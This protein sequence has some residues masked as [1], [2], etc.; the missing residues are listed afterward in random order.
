MKTKKTSTL[1]WLCV[2]LLQYKWLLLLALALTVGSNLFA[3]IGPALCG[4]AIDLAEMGPGKV[5][6]PAVERYALWM[7]LFY[8]AS[9]VMTYLLNVLMIVISRKVTYRM[10]RD[11][12]RRLA[13]LPVGYFDSHP[14]GDIISRISYDTDTINGSLSTDLV[15]IFASVITVAGSLI[16]MLRIAP[17]LVLVFVVTVPLSM[18]ITRR[19]SKKTHPLFRLR[20]R[21]LGE[22][23][24][25]AEEMISGQKTLKA[26]CQEENTLSELDEYNERAVEAYYQAEYHVA[27]MG[28]STNF[29]N[30]LSL[31]LISVFGA[32]MYMAG[33]I[34]VG[35][36]S[37]FVLYSRKFS[38]PIREVADIFNE[39][40][41]SV[42]AAERVFRI[43]DE[44]PEPPDPENARPLGPVQGAVELEH[45]S[46]GYTP[47]R[48]V[49]HDLS[50]QV[51]PGRLIAIVGPTGA[52]KTTL[53][54][55]LMRFYDMDGGK[56]RV[57]GRD[58]AG[59]TRSSL[60]LAYSMVLQDTWLFYGSIYDN[61]AY[62]RP[63]AT[64][65]EVEAAARAAHIDGFI[66]SLP[67]G[68]D[69]ILTD[70]AANISKGQKQLLT[71][72]RAMLMDSPMLILDEATSNVDTRTELLVQQAM[73]ELMRDK[74]CFVVAHRLSTVR[75]ADRILVV[76]DGDIVESGV[77]A[78]LMAKKGFYWELYQAQFA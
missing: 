76:R 11:M 39:L 61:I 19:I 38:G 9:A 77:H 64:R 36:I 27:G 46:F 5:D 4:R 50:L 71:I 30:N 62:G 32:M 55:L 43:M 40:Q 17:K 21:R 13:D 20:S 14:V 3:L 52:G 22:L 34:T 66:R 31:T 68:Y 72:A 16:M 18:L 74:T 45:I 51:Q 37:S 75:H 25:F 53:I 42:A 69:T 8:V 58:C 65:E 29:I 60:R 23:N 12:F 28:P 7:A 56:M 33:G 26:Y 67:Q 73:R 1:R 44:R 57:D 35:N 24:G 78:E 70:D 47:E 41:S 49:L 2:Y 10:R 59:V 6:L 54:N 48:T 15:Q 63:S